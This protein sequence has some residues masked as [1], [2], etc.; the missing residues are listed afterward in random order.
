MDKNEKINSNNVHNS[1]NN[2]RII[3]DA[4]N[5]IAGRICSRV[6]KLLL[7]GNGVV[8]INSEKAMISGNKY[9]IID[10][11]KKRLEVGSITNPIHGPYHP[12]RPDRI[13]SKMVRGMI[14]R[15]KPSGTAAFKRLRVYIGIPSEFKDIKEIKDFEDTRITKSKSYYI[16]I[17]DVAKQIGWK[18]ADN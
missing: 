11:Y 5:C 2:K 12:R 9:R 17:G 1:T 7:Q 18:G 16:T 3:I 14:P 4:D 6:S 15:T 13:L 10:D 8:I